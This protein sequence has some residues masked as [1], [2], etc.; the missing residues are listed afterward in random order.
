[1]DWE[2][3]AEDETVDDTAKALCANGFTTF[4]VKDR[5][6]ARK[7]FLELIPPGSEV[8][9]MSSVTLEQAGI[10]KE[11]EEGNRYVSL[12]KKVNAINDK[13]ARY[14]F[15][16]SAS[17]CDVACGSVHAVT[18][19]GE[20]AIASQSGSQLAPYSFAAAKVVWV[21]GAQK[22]VNDLDSAFRR[23]R[24]HCVP[25]EDERMKSRYGAG[26]GLNKLLIIEKEPTPGRT[27][28]ILVKEKLG[29]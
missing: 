8:Y 6:E 2:K 24:E 25:L 21:V 19:K 20:I 4:I 1:M 5:E 26:T 13:A 17:A 27:K 3:L 12:K 18:K 9:S 10:M 16:R 28:I 14:N 7:K 23:I 29:F 11:I 22:I 15:R